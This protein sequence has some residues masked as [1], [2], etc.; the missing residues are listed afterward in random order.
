LAAPTDYQYRKNGKTVQ[1]LPH[2]QTLQQCATAC[3]RQLSTVK[4]P[5]D[6][7]CPLYL[8]KADIDRNFW[9]VRQ[10]PEAGIVLMAVVR[11]VSEKLANFSGPH[12]VTVRWT[13][14]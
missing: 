6:C 7:E 2:R 9:N 3:I 14:Q 10:V 12:P 5:K 1:K 4:K 11:V 8:L 13:S